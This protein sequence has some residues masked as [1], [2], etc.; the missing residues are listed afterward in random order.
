MY[1]Y[2]GKS[3]KTHTVEFF[4]CMGNGV[5]HAIPIH[6][7]KMG[8]WELVKKWYNPYN[9]AKND[10]KGIFMN[11]IKKELENQLEVIIAL[12]KTSDKNIR[13]LENIEIEPV[14]V[15]SRNRR[16]LYYLKEGDKRKYVSGPKIEKVKKIIQK[17]YEIQANKTLCKLKKELERFLERYDFEEIYKVYDNYSD[18]RKFMI[19]PIIEAE[20]DFIERW[21][22]EHPGGQNSFYGDGLYKTDRGEYVRS[23]SEKIIADMLYQNSIPYQY[24]ALLELGCTTVFPDFT[25]LDLNTR[26]TVYWEHLGLASDEEYAVKNFYKL[27]KYESSNYK[28]GEDLLITQ[29]AEDMP[30]D[31]EL[32][33]AK[34]ARLRKRQ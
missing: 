23:K 2:R 28:L 22:E 31:I 13:R 7:G 8:V 24:E 6:F 25:I 14:E 26:N 12:L 4:E 34:I 9:L 30:L 18:G 1:G 15:V 32:V 17:Q 5:K 27:A 3:S 20:A 29:E 11:N 33:Q 21:Y 19:D 16:H 10:R